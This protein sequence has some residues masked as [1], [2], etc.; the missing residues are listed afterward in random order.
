M[1][2]H[3]FLAFDL[4][5]ESGRTILGTLGDG[6]V[7]TRELTRF[8]NGPA[9]L[10]GHLHWNLLSLF[11]DIKRG[12]RACATQARV[13]PES[14]A[15]D[16]WGVD[17]GLLGKDGSVLGFPYAYRDE[18]TRGMMEEFFRHTPREKVYE[19]TGIQFLPFN[20]LFQLY[21]MVRQRSPLL[22]CARDL[23]FMPDLFTYLLSGEKANEFTIASTSQLLDM[24]SRVWSTELMAGL[25]VPMG[26]LQRV[27]PPGT[28][29]G[30]LVPSVAQE[31]EL[32]EV[33]VIATAGHDTAAAIAAIP[34]AGENWAYISSGTWSLMGIETAEPI[35]T[36]AALEAN[37]TNEGGVSETIRFL[38]NIAGLWLLQQS[39]KEWARDE[40]LSY[41]QLADLAA[42]AKAFRSLVDPDWPEFLNPPSMPD[43]IRQFCLLSGQPAPAAPAEFARCILESLAL[44]YRFTLD[45]L[46]RLT[47]RRVEMIHVI[48]GGSRN[49]LLCQFTADATGLPVV[50]GPAEATATGNIMVQALG[51]GYVRSLAEIRSV[52][53]RSVELK[54]YAP[55]AREDWESAFT[56]FRE[57]IRADIPAPKKTLP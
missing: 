5:A 21:A 19:R 55:Q 52:V 54:A 8:P 41:A 32:P 30:K 11:E 12:L 50:A 38:K 2:A 53:R 31:T 7:V 56:R 4:G 39:R 25:G 6:K 47:D 27:V 42:G 3:H 43:A 1:E 16:T 34:A 15:V 9:R 17:F 28:D 40:E 29:L 46:R 23:L 26:I 18:R 48:G 33:R 49:E 36:H 24:R 44:K 13:V 22:D 45:Q 57:L 14:V 35:I 51:L 10:A 20:S 37:F